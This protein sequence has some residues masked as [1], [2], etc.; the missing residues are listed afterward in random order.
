MKKGWL[1]EN[2]WLYPNI[3]GYELP[4]VL[5]PKSGIIASSNNFATSKHVKHGISYAFS[6][7]HRAKRIKEM[8]EEKIKVKKLNFEDMVNI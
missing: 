2:Q 6:Y 1:K 4:Y 5:N 3:D 8:I 7:S